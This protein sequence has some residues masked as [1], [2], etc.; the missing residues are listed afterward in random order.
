[1][2]SYEIGDYK[3]E[4]VKQLIS[5]G[6]ICSLLD[7]EGFCQYPDDLIYRNI[8]P[9]TRIP[10]TEQEV[11]A[12]ITIAVSVPNIDAKNDCVRN[13]RISMRVYSHADIMKVPGN[14]SNRVD[15]LSAAIDRILNESMVL[16]IGPVRLASNTEHVYDSAHYYRELSF[17]TDDINAKRYGAKQWD[18]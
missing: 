11:K 8:F 12:Y 4:I 10:S 18:Y 13:L 2:N 17:K 3:F 16:G 9:F 15:L 6:E 14:H 1:M 5:D 7:P